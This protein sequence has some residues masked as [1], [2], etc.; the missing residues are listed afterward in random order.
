MEETKTVVKI[1]K[2]DSQTLLLGLIAFISIIQTVQLFRVSLAATTMSVQPASSTT[3]T[4][5]PG[6]PSSMVGGC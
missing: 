2:P 5:A 1:A 3:T 6:E 4:G